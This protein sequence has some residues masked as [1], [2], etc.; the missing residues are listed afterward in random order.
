MRGQWSKTADAQRRAPLQ[1]A[2]LAEK[3]PVRLNREA[4]PADH[5][6]ARKKANLADCSGLKAGHSQR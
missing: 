6:N 4:N 2:G 1:A 3:M 5:R